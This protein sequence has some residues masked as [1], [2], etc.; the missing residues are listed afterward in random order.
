MSSSQLFPWQWTNRPVRAAPPSSRLTEKP[1]A[2]MKRFGGRCGRAQRQ[3]PRLH[4]RIRA[5]RRAR[6]LVIGAAFLGLAAPRVRPALLRRCVPGSPSA[7]RSPGLIPTSETTI[8]N[9]CQRREVSPL[10]R[11]C[12]A[13]SVCGVK[14]FTSLWLQPRHVAESGPWG[15]NW[16]RPM[17]SLLVG[18]GALLLAVFV[19]A[20]LDP[21][22]SRSGDA[23]ERAH[24]DDGCDH[25]IDGTLQP[26]VA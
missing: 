6:S 1:L 11:R 7:C 10:R 2:K 15:L 24:S 23:A 17:F 13:A 9:T 16:R 26:G 21:R 4:R 3:S 19:S 18:L 12:G 8:R 14:R 22:P 25:L 20:M 5:N